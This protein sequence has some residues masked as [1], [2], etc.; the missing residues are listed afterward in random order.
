MRRNLRVD[1]ARDQGE[2]GVAAKHSTD[3]PFLTNAVLL[4]LT[5]L[6]CACGFETVVS[7]FLVDEMTFYSIIVHTFSVIATAVRQSIWSTV[8]K[9]KL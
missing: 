1:V 2:R 8:S 3:Q 4:W 6:F 7:A 9:A 5:L